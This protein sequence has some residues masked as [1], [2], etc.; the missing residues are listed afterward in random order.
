M[1][2]PVVTAM[3]L[4][5][6]VA[7]LE[8]LR[9]AVTVVEFTTVKVP[10]TMLTPL[11]RPVG[12]VAPVRL[13]P[14][15]VTG[16]LRVPVAGRVADAVLID[17]SV[18]PSTVKVTVLLVA[19]PALV[20]LMVL[21]PSAAVVP[22]AI[23]RV[24]VTAVPAALTLTP[25]TVMP[26]PAFT[27]VLPVRLVPVKVTGTTVP[28]TPD[29]TLI[30]ERASLFTVNVTLLLAAPPE[31]VVLT[32]LAPAAVGPVTVNSAVTVLSFTT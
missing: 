19:P 18:G 9:V 10:A 30:V 27:V 24:A 25:L 8:M 16:T 11:P 15:S 26:A 4:A 14:V 6:V 12:P 21:G 31:L 22:D 20:T 3:F 13:V 32:F 5:P 2:I 1:P 23:V 28:R 17:V 7:V 29:G